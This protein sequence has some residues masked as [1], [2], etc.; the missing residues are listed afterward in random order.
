M[1]AFSIALDSIWSHRL[2]SALTALGIVIGVFA[3]VTLTSLGSG[4]SSYVSGQFK[5]FGATLVTVSP[6]TPGH[7]G[8]HGHPRFS[9]VGNVPS[10][11]TMGDVR[12]IAARHSPSIARVVPMAIIPAPIGTAPNQSV[13]L[14]VVGTNASYF[15]AEQMKFARGVFNG[16]GAVLGSK[17]EKALFGKQKHVVGRT[18]YLG[19]TALVV[20]GILKAS[21]GITSTSNNMVF[22]P[23]STGLTSV[24]LKTISEIIVQAKSDQS[25]NQAVS[26]VTRVMNQ[27]HPIRNF[28]V[29][30]DTAFLTTINKTLS[31][32]T[33]FLSGL[34]AI[35]LLVG[36]IGIMNIMLVTVTERFREI[37]IRK[38]L[39][40]RDGDILVQFLAESVLLALL[41][42]AIGVGLSAVASH[43]IGK[44]AGFPA[45]LT[46]GSVVLAIGFS[47]GV[48]IVFGVLPALR[49]SRLMPAEALR[50]E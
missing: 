9:P 3:V 2:R 31:T 39:G 43:L 47:V 44:L 7:T 1:N 25:V 30:K 35:S 16:S 40:A 4:V 38:A 50:T 49:A 13:G 21:T 22:I 14:S 20:S 8:K 6:A 17:A 37:G 24:G 42:G 27:R 48:G 28:A 18:V 12:A 11:L 15:P 32:I 41:G 36:G 26:V 45:G 19:K 29:T 46:V 10:T 33:T 23:V 34:A 5:V